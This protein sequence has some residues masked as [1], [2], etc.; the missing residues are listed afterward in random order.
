MCIVKVLY[1]LAYHGR[2]GPLTVS[3]GLSSPLGNEV[4]RRGMEE[5]GYQMVDCNGPSQTGKYMYLNTSSI[6]QKHLS[7][8]TSVIRKN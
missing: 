3:D 7:I 6:T 8:K 5:L 4:Y 1:A 2:G